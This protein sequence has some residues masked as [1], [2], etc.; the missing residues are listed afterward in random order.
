MLA[1]TR[2]SKRLGSGY[3]KHPM[4]QFA[5]SYVNTMNNIVREGFDFN[6]DP[7][8]SMCNQA[9]MEAMKEFFV[10]ESYDPKGMTPE[11]IEEH[12]QDMT[13]L[14]END[15]EALLEHTNAASI[16]PMVG[17]A[18]PMHKWILMNMV[19]DKGSIPKFVAQ[20]PKFPI[21][22]EYRILVDTKGNELDFFKDQNKMTAA[23]DATAAL[24]TFDMTLPVQDT[25]E[26]VHDK[27]G[28]LAGADHL[29]IETAI[30]ER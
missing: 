9:C 10:E 18:F 21:T 3:E 13:A 7:S 26:I 4:H 24:T 25:T 28:G 1:G 17:L 5:E 8:R 20:Q 15:R 6:M 30:T 27:L 19:F 14:F 16:A 29:S 12:E 23:I 2:P 11:E 22:M